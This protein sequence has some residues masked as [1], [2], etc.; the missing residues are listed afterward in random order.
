MQMRISLDIQDARFLSEMIPATAPARAAIARAMRAREYWGIHGPDVV[1]ECDDMDGL[2]LLS[3]AES[4]CPNA[5]ANIRRA[6][7][8]GNLQQVGGQSRTIPNSI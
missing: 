4:Y 5:A 8:L 1:I 6:F 2:D 3:Y 7:R